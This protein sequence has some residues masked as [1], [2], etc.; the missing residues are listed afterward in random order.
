MI[1]DRCESLG[2]TESAEADGYID[3]NHCQVST[4]LPPLSD[5]LNVNTPLQIGGVSHLP[6]NSSYFV[7]FDGCIRFFRFNNEV[8][9]SF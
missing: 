6:G 2:L 9:S 3:N 7:H 5:Q 8:R 1:Y 4:K